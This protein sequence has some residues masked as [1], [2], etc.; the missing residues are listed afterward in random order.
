MLEIKLTV[1]NTYQI[2][3]EKIYTQK[4][5]CESFLFREVYNANNFMVCRLDR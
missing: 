4:I 3:Q 5:K 1:L 2:L